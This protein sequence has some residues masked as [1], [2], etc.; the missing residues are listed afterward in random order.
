M[1]FLSCRNTRVGFSSLSPH[2]WSL[3]PPCPCAKTK[4]PSSYMCLPLVILNLTLS[5]HT[6]CWHF[7]RSCPDRS[8]LRWEGEGRKTQADIPT[9]AQWI[10]FTGWSSLGLGSVMFGA[11]FAP[12]QQ[13]AVGLNSAKCEAALQCTRKSSDSEPSSFDIFQQRWGR[14]DSAIGQQKDN[15]CFIFA[16]YFKVKVNMRQYFTVCTSKSK[17]SWFTTRLF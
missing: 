1:S 12:W 11:G 6:P 3:L 13:L 5:W 7:S 15:F 2:P 10:Y 4:P 9:F 17:L 8:C 14:H 16:A